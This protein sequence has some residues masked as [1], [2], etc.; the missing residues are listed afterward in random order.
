M[1]RIHNT[2]LLLALLLLHAYGVDAK[3]KLTLTTSGM[4]NASYTTDSNT[5]AYVIKTTGTDPYIYST[6][7]SRNLTSTETCLYFQYKAAKQLNRFQV[8]FGNT[9]TEARSKVLGNLSSSS[10]WKDA[11]FDISS[12]I[13][14]F[15]WKS[16]GQKLRLDFGDVSGLTIEIK[17]LCIR[18]KGDDSLSP[19]EQKEANLQ[20]YLSA[21]F[22]CTIDDVTVGSSKVLITGTTPAEGSFRLVEVPPY[23]NVTE[24]A[25]YT[26][27]QELE[28]GDFSVSLTRKVSQKGFSY[29][30]ALSK[31]AVVET[32]GAKPV[33]VSHAHYADSVVK[34]RNVRYQPLKSKK[35]LGGF[36]I[37]ENI[38]DLSAL[39]ISSVTV[40]MVVNTMI[41]TTSSFGNSISYSFGG[42]TY[43]IDGGQISYFD[44]V[45]KECYNRGIIVSA[46][47]LFAP[48]PADSGIRT[49]TVHPDYSGGYYSMP[50]M[51]TPEG[52]NAYAAIITYLADRYCSATYGRIH[53]WIMHNEV[54]EGRTWTNMGV[55]PLHIYLDEYQKSMRLVYNIARQYYPSTSVLA[56]FTHTWTQNTADGAG[57]N[58]YN[59]L[60]KSVDYSHS[61][62]DYSWGVAYHP[63]PQ[64]LLKPRFWVDDTQST[65]SMSTKYCTFKNLEVIATWM[66]DSDHLYK[67]QHKRILFLSENGTNSP[68]YTDTQLAY[69]AAGACWAWKKVQALDAI[70][71]IQWH[72]WRD[73]REEF[74]LCIG[75]RRYPDDA[76]DPN[77]RKPVW[78]VWQ[79]AGTDREDE[80]FDPYLTY[81]FRSSWDK[82][83]DSNMM[84]PV[85]P[86]FAQEEEDASL[87]CRFYTLDGKF[88]YECTEQPSALP[89]RPG[90]YV[91]RRGNKSRKMLVR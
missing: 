67:G 38:G 27:S 54:D 62:G 7:L 36:V 74:G 84:T 13:R 45:L 85:E 22:P 91:M 11:E 78:Y 56:S 15:S 19:E 76:T 42:K 80:V 17:D 88:A 73:N 86:S 41:S 25:Q 18:A 79:A 39:G 2:L 34:K 16:S 44:S 49:A 33:L 28:N 58:T 31:W 61:E 81:L 23:A 68:D 43:Y 82:I 29:D 70:D 53:Y 57:F 46:I 90:I 77:G 66:T 24:D 47:L 72:N 14:D 30:R 1:K 89:L 21:S 6:G 83:F 10:E 40:N 52:V 8:Y 37:N 63:Y 50:N 12:C 48:T 87:P 4:N 20:K 71:A 64:S 35:G 65:Y 5:G 32:S 26:F 55:K 69:Q 9:F 60:E 51:T 75:L 3:L 59:M